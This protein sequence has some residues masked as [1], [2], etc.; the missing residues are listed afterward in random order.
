MLTSFWVLTAG[1]ELSK[2]SSSS[3]VVEV[4][5]APKSSPPKRSLSSPSSIVACFG[6]LVVKNSASSPSI[7]LSRER[8]SP[9]GAS[10]EPTFVSPA[11]HQFLYM[12]LQGGS[13]SPASISSIEG[14]LSAIL[15][16]EPLNC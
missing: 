10:P 5:G 3:A 12:F 8:K 15:N 16:C 7:C 9:C 2:S 11:I 6:S 14:N 1:N 4:W 13:F